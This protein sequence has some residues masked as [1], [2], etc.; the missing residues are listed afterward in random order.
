MK[1]LSSSPK[2]CAYV[3]VT[4]VVTAFLFSTAS[5]R[6]GLG[7]VDVFVTNGNFLQRLISNGPLNAP[8]GITMAPAGFVS[9]PSGLLVSNFGN[10]E[11][12]TFNPTTGSLL[13]T[14]SDSE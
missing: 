12:N 5:P 14:I 2:V 4:L 13:E 11:I 6:A 8:W 3:A 9:F 10:G 7:F 1:M